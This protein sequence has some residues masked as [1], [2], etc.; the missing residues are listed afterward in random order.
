MRYLGGDETLINE[1]K[2]IRRLQEEL[3]AA[4][5][6]H[7]ARLFGEDVER[8]RQR[9]P[10][11]PEWAMEWRESRTEQKNAGKNLRAAIQSIGYDSVRL[12]TS[13]ENAKNQ[14]VV[15]FAGNTTAFKK[16]HNIPVHTALADWMTRDQLEMRRMMSN[17]LKR[18]FEAMEDPT[19]LEMK[20]LAEDIRTKTSEMC[21][22][23]G[24]Q[25]FSDSH[26]AQ[27]VRQLE[28]KHAALEARTQALEESAAAPRIQNYFAATTIVNNS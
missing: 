17:K 25:G 12:G 15:G 20:R 10:G 22:F 21:D 24:I 19:A 11:L 8:Q 16:Q 4:Q 6:E 23:M 5:P 2:D 27:Q 14:A 13:V 18:T 7:P 9:A 3:R 26:W 28:V 1:I